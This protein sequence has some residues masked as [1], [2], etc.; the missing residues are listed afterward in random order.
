MRPTSTGTPSSADLRCSGCGCRTTGAGGVN[1]GSD[2]Q[3][4]D[5]TVAGTH[6]TSLILWIRIAGQSR[7]T[8]AGAGAHGT[9]GGADLCRSGGNSAAQPGE[10]ETGWKVGGRLQW[11]HVAVSAQVTVYAILPGRGYEQSVKML[12]ADYDGFLVHDG[13]APYYRF[14]SAFH[15]IK[16]A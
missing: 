11:L 13:W 5:G 12:G 6:T 15:Q 2:P 9:S 14:P 10:W 3:Q 1:L 16:V 4:A 8:V 7:R